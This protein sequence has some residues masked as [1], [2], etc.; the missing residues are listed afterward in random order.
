[1]RYKGYEIKET[2]IRLP[3]S[4]A[5]VATYGIYDGERLVSPVESKALAKRVIDAHTG[6]GIWKRKEELSNG[7]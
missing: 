2:I 4:T 5:P 7:E 6:A 3:I 1:M